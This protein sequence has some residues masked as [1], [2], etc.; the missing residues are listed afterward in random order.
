MHTRQI[1]NQAYKNLISDRYKSRPMVVSSCGPCMCSSRVSRSIF[2]LAFARSA[3]RGNFL[4]ATANLEQIVSKE[5]ACSQ[6]CVGYSVLQVPMRVVSHSPG[7]CRTSVTFDVSIRQP[8]YRSSVKCSLKK[9]QVRTVP[10]KNIPE[11]S[12]L[13]VV[14]ATPMPVPVQM[15]ADRLVDH[16]DFE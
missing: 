8:W 14:G 11:H 10:S 13:M 7:P 3:H 1:Q 16:V 6:I 12:H 5:V 15:R 9:T 4:H 2:V